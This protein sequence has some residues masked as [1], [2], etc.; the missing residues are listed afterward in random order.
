MKILS[1]A[2]CFCVVSSAYAV[3]PSASPASAE[4]FLRGLYAKYTPNGKPTPFVYPDAK[5]V[6]DPGMM[7]LLR[8]DRDMSKGEVGAI[9][10][11][12]VC[13]CQDWDGLKI[14]SLHVTM[15]GKNAASADLALTNAGSSEKIH[16]LLVWTKGGWRIHDIGTKD[17]PSLVT[18][19]KTYKY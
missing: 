6:A 18:Y 13:D 10:A 16:F 14:T 3:A 8:H 15:Q 17:T 4:Q 19:L 12:P 9:D 11:D 7:S 2:L 1:L 5:T